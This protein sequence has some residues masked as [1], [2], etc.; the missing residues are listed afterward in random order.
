MAT[1]T[2]AITTMIVLRV[3]VSIIGRMGQSIVVIFCRV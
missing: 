3:M 1:C 2:L